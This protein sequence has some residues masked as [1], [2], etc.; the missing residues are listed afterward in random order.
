MKK[1][2]LFVVVIHCFLNADSRHIIGGE[3]I[4]EYLRPGNSPGSRVFRITL[5]LFRDELSGGAVLPASVGMAVFNNDNNS[6]V[7]TYRTVSQSYNELVPIN[8]LP[9]CISNAPDLQ[10]RVG[11]YPFEIELLSNNLGYTAAYQTCCRVD[12]AMNT[13]NNM[14]ATYVSRIPA[15]IQDNSPRFNMGIDVVCYQKPFT[16]DFSATDADGDSL[17]YSFCDAYNGG[18]A[19][20]ASFNT[21]APPPYGSITYTNGFTGSRPLGTRA[22]INP[23][24]GIIS[25]I[26]PNSG[27]YVISVCVSSYK[28]GTFVGTHRK[29]FIVTVAACD[30]AGAELNPD[31][32]SCDGFTFNFRNL[33]SSPLNQTFSWDFG[34]PGSGGQN[35]STLSS[36]THTFSDTGIYSITV[37]VNGGTGC[38]DTAVAT[39]KVYPGFFPAFDANSPVC[40]GTPLAFSDQTTSNYGQPNSW[41]W[42]FGVFSTQ[43]DTSRLQNPVYTYADTGTY[44]VRLIVGSNKGCLDTVFRPVTVVSKPAIQVTNDTLICRGDT[45]QLNLSSGT[46]GNVVW[47]PDY[48]ISDIN[49]FTPLVFPAVPTT[50]ALSYADNFG[51]AAV[52]SV[53]INMIDSVWT[54]TG[55]D[56]TICLSDPIRL[57]L[58]SNALYYSWTPAATLDDSSLKNPLAT[59]VD[60]LTTYFVTARVSNRCFRTD[61]VLVRTVPYPDADAGPDTTICLGASAFLSA[62]GGNAYSWTPSTYLS[63][64]GVPNPAVSNPASSITYIVKVTD[65]LG[66]P[67]PSFDTVNVEVLNVQANAGS[68]TA[69]V[70]GQPLQLLGSGGSAYNWS[71]STYLN[72]SGINNPICLPQSDISYV[73]TVTDGPGCLDTDTLRIKLYLFDADIRVPNAFTPDGDGMNDIIRPVAIGMQSVDVFRIYNR[74]GEMVYSTSRINQGWDG[75]YRGK[76]QS[77]GTFVWYAEGITY[78]NR[79]IF[80]K[81]YV[82]LIR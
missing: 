2:I 46:P 17:V 6:I 63:D 76:K 56:T 40:K 12:G 82:L 80:R 1:I 15:N 57:T 52:D 3:V 27:E 8:P 44:T 28:N 24:T 48:N 7:G 39:V 60:P 33:N 19:I 77:T 58:L 49:S 41:I 20:D 32:L 4:Y 18:Q 23:N 61:S 79:R 42:N 35:I 45:L 38:S 30:F 50:Y 29:D 9:L 37:V 21:P 54:F 53:K 70:I 31:Y 34:D 73:L 68:D 13:V 72:N 64:P 81:G 66:C 65:A 47:S 26:A 55:N 14:G 25:G 10:Y 51:C 78:D 5:R 16:M 75:V 43:T 36:P 69:V 22:A 67:K 11:Y 59:P 74:F 62:V 71:P